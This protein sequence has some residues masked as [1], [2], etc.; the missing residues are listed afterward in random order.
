MLLRGELEMD[1]KNSI[2]EFFES[3][4]CMKSGNMPL[5]FVPNP[6]FS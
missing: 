2:F 5:I 1:A 3:T 6:V 4:L